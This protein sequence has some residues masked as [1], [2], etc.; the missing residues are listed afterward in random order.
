MYRKSMNFHHL[1]IHCC[2]LFLLV[3]FYTISVEFSCIFFFLQQQSFDGL[4]SSTFPHIYSE[5]VDSTETNQPCQ[6]FACGYSCVQIYRIFVFETPGKENKKLNILV[7]MCFQLK[8]CECVNLKVNKRKTIRTELISK[9][10][11]KAFST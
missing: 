6:T 7:S 2:C 1:Q 8:L 3:Y 11:Q 4:S 9:F 5:C 10:I